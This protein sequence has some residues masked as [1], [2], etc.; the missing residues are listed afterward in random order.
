M[1]KNKPVIA[2]IVIAF[3]TVAQLLLSIFRHRGTFSHW[4]CSEAALWI[5]AVAS[6]KCEGWSGR[7]DKEIKDATGELLFSQQL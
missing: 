3:P 2:G 5:I 1:G 7:R 6:V 4:K